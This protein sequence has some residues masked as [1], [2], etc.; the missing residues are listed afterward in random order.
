MIP[1][2]WILYFTTVQLTFKQAF[3]KY[4][5]IDKPKFFFNRNE[6]FILCRFV[7]LLLFRTRLYLVKIIKFSFQRQLELTKFHTMY[8]CTLFA[9][10][11]IFVYI[12]LIFIYILIRLISGFA[13]KSLFSSLLFSKFIYFAH[14]GT[15]RFQ[16]IMLNFRHYH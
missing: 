13:I 10:I 12:T 8:R 7:S 15:A 3:T 16:S 11:P 9:M 6:L 4:Q 14:N 1:I 2:A 5:A